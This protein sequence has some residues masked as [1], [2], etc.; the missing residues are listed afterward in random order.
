M[1]CK[2]AVVLSVTFFTV[3]RKG[4]VGGGGRCGTGAALKATW[5]P[6]LIFYAQR[7]LW[8]VAFE[9]FIAVPHKATRQLGVACHGMK[10][11]VLAAV[12]PP[13]HSPCPSLSTQFDCQKHVKGVVV[14]VVVIGL[15]LWGKKL[16]TIESNSFARNHRRV[17]LRDNIVSCLSQWGPSESSA[18]PCHA[19]LC[20]V[21]SCPVLCCAILSWTQPLVE[22]CWGGFEIESRNA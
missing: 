13:F 1:S 5:N 15:Q 21:L 14:V 16:E 6:F 11:A 19:V 22:M 7:P 2:N 8:A 18:V 20:P 10:P 9:Q 3:W 17:K 4:E 12:H